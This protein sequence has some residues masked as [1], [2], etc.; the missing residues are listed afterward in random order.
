MKNWLHDIY[1][2]PTA[3]IGGGW[4]CHKDSPS[5]P[6]QPNYSQVAVDQGAAN[7]DTALATARISNAN[8]N[9]PYGNQSVTWSGVNGDIPIIDQSLSPAGQQLLDSSNR[10]SNNVAGVAESGV[11]RVGQAMATPFDTSQIH[12]LQADPAARQAAQDA[13]YKQATSRLDPQ[14]ATQQTNMETQLRNQGLVPGS[15]AYDAA[16]KNFNFGKND[17]YSSAYNNSFNNGLAAEQ[18]D[19]GMQTA[20]NTGNIQNQNFVRS[21]PLNELNAL[22][23][24]AQVTNPQFAAYNPTQ[25]AQT[26]IMQAAQAGAAGANNIYN[27]QQGAANSFNSGLMGI[28]GTAGGMYGASKYAPWNI[29]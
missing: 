12:T 6:P 25:V 17:A 23:T 20:A 9:T 2:A 4:I 7:K 14:F 18:T 15:E 27:V 13:A 16:M 3:K 19:L 8:Y 1:W 24:G 22:R 10:I 29:G 5:P 11:N 28:A 26:P 21:L